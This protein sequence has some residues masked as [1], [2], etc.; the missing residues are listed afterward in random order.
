MSTSSQSVLSAFQSPG[1][2]ANSQ[3]SSQQDTVP[4][5]FAIRAPP[6][7]DAVMKFTADSVGSVYLALLSESGNFVIKNERNNLLEINQKGEEIILGVS[8]VKAKSLQF[9]G[10]ILYKD[11]PQWKLV[12]NENFWKEPTGWTINSIST[13]GGV[14]MLGGYSIISGQENSKQFK[15]LPAHQKIRITATFHFIDAWIGETAYM[16]VDVGR[17][18]TLEYVW[19]ERYD[20]TMA[21]NAI[22]VCGA[23]YGEGK[24][25]SVIDITLPHIEDS[26]T[27]LFGSNLSQDP[28][29]E[30]WGI[31]NL[32]IYVM[33]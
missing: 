30:S 21:K 9:Y 2:P 29:E 23:H 4:T 14:H 7:S 3:E 26:V 33:S 24:F 6:G 16:K 28:Q 27:I 18:R 31:S 25:T 20:S 5:T 10:D 17:N 11:I 22:N 1:T 12:I 8:K 32:S 19:T 15:E 13:C